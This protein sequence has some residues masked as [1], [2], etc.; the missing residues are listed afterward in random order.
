MDQF[1]KDTKHRPHQL[2]GIEQKFLCTQVPTFIDFRHIYPFVST[3]LSAVEFKAPNVLYDYAAVKHIEP[4]TLRNL[5][6]GATLPSAGLHAGLPPLIKDFVEEVK[7]PKGYEIL[8]FFLQA[9]KRKNLSDHIDALVTDTDERQRLFNAIQN[10]QVPKDMDMKDIVP[11][12]GNF[13][14]SLNL[15]KHEIE[16]EPIRRH[17]PPPPEEE[18]EEEEE[19]DISLP[20][21]DPSPF[22]EQDHWENPIL[23]QFK[24]D[25]GLS[26][27]FSSEKTI[28]QVLV[29]TCAPHMA[30]QVELGKFQSSIP[31]MDSASHDIENFPV[32]YIDSLPNSTISE[33]VA[34]PEA[35]EL[36]NG[37]INKPKTS[38]EL[39]KTLIIQH[40]PHLGKFVQVSKNYKK[41]DRLNEGIVKKLIQ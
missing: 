23:K 18:E 40:H 5:L 8:A 29:G 41:A 1:I 31:A 26:T 2:E 11:S 36:Y 38:R 19:R 32:S 35:R 4:E 6:I 3:D 37:L 21:P 34:T 25:A 17:V 30:D 13:I 16:E 9:Q 39:V 24:I 10:Y 28:K 15:V 7:P 33:I 12:I 22:C 27:R 20:V 14:A